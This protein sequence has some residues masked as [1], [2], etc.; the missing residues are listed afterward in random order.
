MTITTAELQRLKPS[1]LCSPY[2]V[3]E[4]TTHKDTPDGT[5]CHKYSIPI[6]L[7]RFDRVEL[8]KWA[9]GRIKRAR[10]IEFGDLADVA[11]VV[12]RELVE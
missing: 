7:L 5:L 3:A 2:V 12:K 1:G 8:L 4:A 9:D 10:A 6:Q 11:Q